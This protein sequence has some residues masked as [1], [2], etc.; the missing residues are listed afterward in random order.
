MLTPLLSLEKVRQTYK[1]ACNVFQ[2]YC[3]EW[4]LT[5]NISKTKIIIFSRG[6]QSKKI[7]FSFDAD[8]ES[9]SEYKY[10]GIYLS[11]TYYYIKAKKH[12]AEQ[13]N[14]A[15]LS[16]LKKIRRLDLPFDLQI[17]LFNKTVKPILLYGCEFLGNG[18]S[19]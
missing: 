5:V 15:L 19:K 3:D 10:L 11:R 13:A 17:T 14:K 12:V 7:C 6:R 18:N 4:K 2:I 8:F 1:K 9:V 16:L